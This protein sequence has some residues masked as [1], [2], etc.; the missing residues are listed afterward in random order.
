MNYSNL[1][2]DARWNADHGIGR[3]SRE[4]SKS[5]TCKR[6]SDI[7]GD[8]DDIFSP[9]D[10]LLLWAKIL[11][12]KKT[13]I[14]P[15]YNVPA[16]SSKRAIITIHDLMHI[17]FY[18]SIKNKLYYSLLVKKVCQN[19][20][21]IF[22][23]SNYTK[24]EICEW[25]NIDSDKVIVIYNGVDEQFNYKV[26]PFIHRRPYLLY[27]GNKKKHKNIIRLIT[28]YSKSEA[29]KSYDLLI[30]GEPDQKLRNL[31]EN[32]SIS[33]KVFF[34]G[35][36]K[37]EQL[38]AYYKGAHAFLMPS[39]YEGFGLPIIEAMAV[40]TPVLTSNITA[41]PEIAGD[42][43]LLVNPYDIDDIAHGINRICFDHDLRR[44][45]SNA[46]LERVKLFNWDK[47]RKIWDDALEKYIGFEKK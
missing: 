5:K 16:F 10:P 3:F 7:K 35:F 15:S 42:A 26:L 30:S 22:T 47:T 20:P 31:I 17:R 9:L 38:P 45:L 27:I 37:E 23:V 4:I 46:G 39:L 12:Q 11:N 28:G 44:K 6:I 25:A 29:I 2:Y 24:K 8:F 34:T 32:L 40:G 13:F 1:L 18:K 33:G 14:S 36:I 41:M 43:A 21:I 19:S